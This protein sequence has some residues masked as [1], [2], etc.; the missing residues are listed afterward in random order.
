MPKSNPSAS[1]RTQHSNAKSSGDDNAAR[2]SDVALRKKKNA[3]AQAAFRARRAN[4]IATLEE[5]VTS[6]ESVV[7]QLQESCR[8][9]R[10]EALELRQDN[11]RLRY[12]LREREKYWRVLWQSRKAGQDP[13]DATPPLP[14][15]P[16][17]ALA[18]PNVH[19]GPSHAVQYPDDSVSYRPDEPSTSTPFNGSENSYASPSIPLVE[20]ENGH[21]ESSSRLAKYGAYSYPTNTINGSPRDSRW[22]LQVL[23][24]VNP[25]GE[26]GTQT[27]IYGESPTLTS[28]EMSFTG[29]AAEETKPALHNVLD[30]APYGFATDERFPQR[31]N[32]G[33]IPSDSRSISPT[34]STAQTASSSAT[35]LTSPFNFTFP[36]SSASNDR[37]D[38]DFRRHSLPQGEITL[39]GG[40]ADIT[41]AG[42]AGSDAVRYR[43]NSRKD[44]LGQL[45][46][47]VAGNDNGGASSDRTSGDDVHSLA[48]RLRR[49]RGTMPSSRSPSPGLPSL[50]STVA[51]IKAQA[52]GALRRTRARGKK[53]SEG[54]AK[55]AMDVLEARGIGIGG[56]STGSKRQRTDS[57]SME[58]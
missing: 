10:A 18:P 29:Y 5:T 25:G 14:P 41:M 17:A 16:S 20:Q 58:S 54:A 39:H 43:L 28:P 19:I 37:R 21:D 48:S 40:T 56:P 34:A 57:D 31:L 32:D 53:S 26:S 33:S 51:V 15:L 38:F 44:V 36:D 8:E 2:L 6:L 49:R 12:E 7:I 27:P 50:S 30:R 11:V 4:Y 24:V 45:P 52:F 55:V 9:S 42:L 3:D 35:S 47:V 1:P 22:P 13:D 46:P 23:P